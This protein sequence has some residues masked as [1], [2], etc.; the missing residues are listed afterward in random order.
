[1]PCCYLYGV[2]RFGIQDALTLHPNGGLAHQ[3]GLA[4]ARN[5]YARG[6]GSGRIASRSQARNANRKI[7]V[8]VFAFQVDKMQKLGVLAKAESK[9]LV[10]GFKLAV[11][12]LQKYGMIF[13]VGLTRAEGDDVRRPSIPREHYSCIINAVGITFWVYSASKPFCNT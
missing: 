8:I 10:P 1:L 13:G 6:S 4:M 11:E 12:L 7:A 2:E 9:R 3:M 5:S